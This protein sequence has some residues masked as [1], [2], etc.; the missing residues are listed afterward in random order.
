VLEAVV[1]TLAA[2]GAANQRS[3]LIAALVMFRAVYYLLPLVA[4]LIVGG[5][6]ELLPR[7]RRAMRPSTVSGA[8]HVR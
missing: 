2:T 7:H 1:L 6:S 8:L 3:A 5:L 4:A